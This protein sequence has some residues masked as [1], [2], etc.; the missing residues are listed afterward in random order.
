M[1]SIVIIWIA[2]CCVLPSGCVKHP[3]GPIKIGSQDFTEQKILAE[4]MALLAEKEGLRVMR[5]IPYGDNRQSLM[6]IQ[7]GILDAYPEYNGSLLS[8]S[9]GLAF[10]YPERHEPGKVTAAVKDLVEP[11][12]LQWLG[13]FGFNNGYTI[14]VRRDVA[15]R[16]ELNTISDLKRLPMSL[17]VAAD[18]NFLSR[19]ADGLH[20]MAR[21]YGLNLG[22]VKAFPVAERVNAYGALVENR[23]DMVE[24]F[25]TDAYLNNYGLTILSDN[26]K[27]FP[28]Y[29]P[30]PLV[31]SDVL[32]QFPRLAEA[33]KS[34]A[35]RIDLSTMR[36]LNER[37]ELAGEDF[38]DVARDHLSKMGLLPEHLD[39]AASR[40]SLSLA[41]NPISDLGFLPIRAAEA[42]RQVMPARR[43]IV[44]RVLV[45]AAAVRNG[46]VRF[47][48][49]GAEAFYQIDEDDQP[50]QV[51]DMEAVGVVGNRFA[52]LVTVSGVA[53]PRQWRRIGTGPEGS[54]S[55]LVARLVLIALK[56]EDNIQLIAIDDPAN[57]PKMLA[58]RRVDALMLMVEQ[59]HAALLNLLKSRDFQLVDADAFRGASPALRYPFLR[60]ARIPANTYPGQTDPLDTVTAQVVLATRIPQE[61]SPVGEFGPGF[62]PGVFTR[63]PQRLPFETAKL[64]SQALNVDEEVDPVLPRSPGLAIE[65]PLIQPR[66]QTHIGSALLNILAIGFI[67]SMVFLF[68]RR[69]PENPALKSGMKKP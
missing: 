47:G 60:P 26:L 36:Q 25:Q 12:G 54:S 6:A 59:G 4:M 31:R 1:R 53:D 63:L 16:Y 37:V 13:P 19:T 24:V 33:L 21:R 18:E 43:L 52:H 11:L 49:V 55:W 27:F 32:E 15:I 56:L 5:A 22:S 67:A 7:K 44:K 45:P 65:T 30:A 42:I 69:L 17:R 61:I 58:D 68:F 20:A 34:L 29:E 48:L 64:I 50:V 46:D 41:V 2:L 40:G 23:V 62:V 8:L 38:R 3:E 35:G 39:A 51:Q 66:I 57:A 28:P 9:G 14:A 10:H